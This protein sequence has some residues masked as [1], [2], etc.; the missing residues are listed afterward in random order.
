MRQAEIKREQANVELTAAQR[1]LLR[2]LQ[3]YYQE[4]QVARAQV[5]SLRHS[6]DLSVETL[7]LTGLKYQNGEANILEL[8]D[9]QTLL[10]QARNSYDDAL[11]RYRVALSNL[12]TL[13]GTF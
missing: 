4:A 7:R 2:N 12:Q 9:A 1:T 13:T 6:V 11:V 8:V 10:I 5:E 3:A